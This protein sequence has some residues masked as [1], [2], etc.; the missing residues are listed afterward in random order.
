MKKLPK[1]LLMILA[2]LVLGFMALSLFVSTLD[3]DK[4]RPKLVEE[5]TKAT[6]RPAKLNGP[7][8]F[9]LGLRGIKVSV[10]DAS[11]GNPAWASRPVLAGMGKFELNIS[12]LPLLSHRVA[13]N[14][15]TIENA[16]ILLETNAA[17]QHNWDFNPATT[18]KPDVVKPSAA[19]TAPSGSLSISNLTITNSQ[20]AMRAADGKVSSYNVASL[21]LVM[22]SSGAEI[23]FKGDINSAPI[24]LD[25]KTN[26]SD[27]LS[28]APF[29]FE[30]DMTY[31]AIHLTAKGSV[32]LAGTKAQISDL[33]LTAGKTKVTG[34]V[35]AAWGGARPAIRGAVL[36]DHIDM[37]D[38]K[39]A[40][41]DSGDQP[42]ASESGKPG[43]KRMF[44]DAPL[45]LDGLKAA[46]AD[47]DLSVA[48]FTLGKSALKQISA[49]LVLAEGS[50]TLAPVKATVGG[51]PL[52]VQLKLNAA[53]L[54]AHLSFG[55]IGNGVDLGDL[56]KLGSMAPFMTGKAGAN[57]QLA[58]EGNSAHE[59]A[60]SLGGVIVITAEKGEILT[61]AASG[62][63]STLATLFDPKGGNDA[64][65][66][67]AARFIAKGGVLSDNGI[68]IDS[69]TSMV[70]GKG[71]VNLGSENVNLV[72]HAKTKLVDVGGL[73]PAL[74]I[75]GPLNDPGYSVDA[76]GMVK[77]VVGSLLNGN[78]NVISSD[79]PD[80]QE[81]PQ[82]QNS[83]VYTLDHP[84]AAS[85]SSSLLP[86]GSAAKATQQ[87]QNFGNSLVKGLFGK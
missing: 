55:M 63:S 24:T 58:G 73:V 77:N 48:D 52:D 10:Q 23:K 79:V 67:L 70:A 50:L 87:I 45:P 15:L 44:S 82:G 74:Q 20:L 80:M 66:C 38:F 5:I 18:T 21:R 60:S 25:L 31:N 81:A 26:I 9:S 69:A 59:I 37:A 40:S 46:D 6:G 33:N 29:T 51:A 34:H 32:D 36:S 8:S 75:S 13:V 57:I 2:L 71:S 62:I 83:C 86:A 42:A 56:Q 72:L 84:K 19:S 49:K 4:Y 53:S 16:D 47:L 11:I 7:I 78:V 1:I 39:T 61:G 30:A 76:V 27:L 64:L 3:A 65:N 22:A 85:S 43:A 68:L 28:K 14:E 54:P 12:L 35:D 41:S 17:G